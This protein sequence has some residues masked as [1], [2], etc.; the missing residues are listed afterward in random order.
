[1]ELIEEN[2]NVVITSC[3]HKFHAECLFKNISANGYKCPNC[4]GPLIS[5]PDREPRWFIDRVG[6]I[7]TA[8]GQQRQ[9][10]DISGSIVTNDASSG[11]HSDDDYD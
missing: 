1:M 9:Y 8:S 11:V 10:Y 7:I 5:V 3:L 6:D 4:R 2:K